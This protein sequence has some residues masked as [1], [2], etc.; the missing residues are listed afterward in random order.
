[1]GLPC[2][3]SSQRQEAAAAR[4]GLRWW[5]PDVSYWLIRGLALLGLAWNVKLPAPPAR[6]GANA[7]PAARH[8][9]GSTW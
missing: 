6:P 9:A 2:P 1:M 8:T 7:A 3:S 4:H 5:Q